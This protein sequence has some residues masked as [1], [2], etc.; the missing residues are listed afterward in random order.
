MRT[1]MNIMGRNRAHYTR[2]CMEENAKR[3]PPQLIAREKKL[4]ANKVIGR[5]NYI[6]THNR[7]AEKM[8]FYI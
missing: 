6:L 2:T 3:S 5:N 1:K 7:P 8:K 4:P